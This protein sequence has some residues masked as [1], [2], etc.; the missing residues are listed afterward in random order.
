MTM[1]RRRRESRENEQE[2]NEEA[3]NTNGCHLVKALQ[4]ERETER[5]TER[6][7]S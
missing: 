5:V 6:A 1:G 4:R 7:I 3:A 2:E